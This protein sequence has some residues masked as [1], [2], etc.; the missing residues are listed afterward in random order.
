MKIDTSKIAIRPGDIGAVFCPSLNPRFPTVHRIVQSMTRDQLSDY[1]LHDQEPFTGYVHYTLADQDEDLAC[2][3]GTSERTAIGTLDATIDRLSLVIRYHP[4]REEAL[5]YLEG[6]EDFG[7]D[8]TNCRWYDTKDGIFT[9]IARP[10]KSS[11]PGHLI[12]YCVDDLPP[13][14]FLGCWAVAI[15][16]DG[17][18]IEDFSDFSDC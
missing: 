3:P 14:G 7:G 18:L 15:T 11:W 4:S 1:G 2:Y 16:P 5:A 10:T 8:W 13:D 6:V 9:L 17:T 12:I